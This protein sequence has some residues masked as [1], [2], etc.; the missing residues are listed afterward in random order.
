MKEILKS[1]RINVEKVSNTDADS[2]RRSIAAPPPDDPRVAAAKINW[3]PRSEKDISQQV[4][5]RDRLRA[6]EKQRNEPTSTPSACRSSRHRKA[7]RAARIRHASAASAIDDA[8]SELAQT[9]MKLNVQQDLSLAD[10][11]VDIHK[12]HAQPPVITPP[13]EPV[14]RAAPGHAF[15]Q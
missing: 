13:T 12:H 9:A 7:D 4:P 2:K 11:M 8:K 5:R 3:P 6:A 14:G 1:K 15:E 10:H